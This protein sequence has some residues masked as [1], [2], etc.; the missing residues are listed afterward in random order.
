MERPGGRAD[1]GSGG[2]SR[3]ADGS[4]HVQLRK[5]VRLVALLNL[6]Y[7][8]IEFATARSVR[9]VSLFADSIDFLED[10]TVNLLIL[11]ALGWPSA[12]RARVGQLLAAILLV[13]GIAT[14]WTAWGKVVAPEA[15]SPVA[16]GLT[17]TGALAVNL[18]CAIHL[19]RFRNEG[20]SLTK[21]AFLSARNDAIANFGII[22]AAFATRATAS[23]WP[24]LLVGLGIFA[25]NLDAAGE[26]FSAAKREHDRANE[27]AAE[28]SPAE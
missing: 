10:A 14:L 24:D 12:R 28:R 20:G 17:G 1:S 3:Q 23:V 2:E 16:L 13:P 6:L 18:F 9:S 7:F 15:P 26:V 5:A 25:M 8:G 22:A 11:M 27:S 4:E 19:V 21:A